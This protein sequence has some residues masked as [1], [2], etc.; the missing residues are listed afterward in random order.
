VAANAKKKLSGTMAERAD[1]HELYE[2]SVQAVDVEAE[3]LQE[4]FREL[5]GREA[6]SFREDFCGTASAA[7]EWVKASDTRHAVG[8]DIDTTVL[9]WGR[10]NRVA[11]LPEKARARVKLLNDDVR[12]VS[13]DPV[14]VVAAFNFSYYCFKTRDEMRG[15]FARVRDALSPD[16]VFFLDAFGGPD[17][18]EL[19]KEKTKHDGF[20]YVWEQAEFEPV[21]SRLLCYI[22][23]RFP[24]GSKIKRAFAYDWRLWTLP[25]LRELLTEAGFSKVR[26]YWEGTDDDDEGDGVFA[27]TATGEPD[28]AWIA[29]IVAE[30]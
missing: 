27:E 5:R 6:V 14:D 28:L 2:E 7:C 23:F 17:A 19:Q 10:R 25:E 29:Y 21:T 11:R 26:I 20:T 30:K 16:G 15:Y 3:F 1:I 12:T 22:H 4:T 8:V 13:T 9:D 18:S 24:D